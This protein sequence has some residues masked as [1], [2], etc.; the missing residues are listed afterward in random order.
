MP[1]LGSGGKIDIYAPTDNKVQTMNCYFKRLN[2][3][4]REPHGEPA[5]TRETEDGVL[6]VEMRWG[7]FHTEDNPEP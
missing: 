6:E 2:T 5:S 1:V 7:P 4:Q 3:P